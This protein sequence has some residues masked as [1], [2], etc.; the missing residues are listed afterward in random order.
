MLDV[1]MFCD[2]YKGVAFM[3]IGKPYIIHWFACTWLVIG[4]VNIGLMG[5]VACLPTGTSYECVSEIMRMR[6]KMG[7]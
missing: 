5:L 3:P 2:I 1:L 4:S 6:I 7:R